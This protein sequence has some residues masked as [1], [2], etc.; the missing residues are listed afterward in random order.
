MGIA[1]RAASLPGLV[2]L[3]L[4]IAAVVFMSVPWK[5]PVL[6]SNGKPWPGAAPQDCPESRFGM[7]RWDEPFNTTWAYNPRLADRA[8][9]CK[10]RATT[11]FRWL[12]LGGFL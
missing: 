9:G 5:A 10:A 11:T 4:L 2:C 12:M 1:V 7:V 6:D 8:E 3:L